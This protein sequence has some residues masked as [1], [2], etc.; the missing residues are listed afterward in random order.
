MQFSK[1]CENLSRKEDDSH[2]KVY[3]TLP[4]PNSKETKLMSFLK[5]CHF[6]K[7]INDDHLNLKKGKQ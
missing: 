2:R 7:K 3:G 1:R 5:S 4:S 6:L